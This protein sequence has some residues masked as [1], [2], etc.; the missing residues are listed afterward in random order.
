MSK[1]AGKDSYFNGSTSG[2]VIR[3]SRSQNKKG[4][5]NWID[6]KNRTT[7]Y[8]STFTCA[9]VPCIRSIF[10]SFL[11]VS[12]TFQLTFD[13]VRWWIIELQMILQHTWTVAGTP[14]V[15]WLPCVADLLMSILSPTLKFWP[16]G[17]LMEALVHRYSATQIFF[18]VSSATL[19]QMLFQ[20]NLCSG[21]RELYV[22]ELYTE[23]RRNDF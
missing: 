7:L 21:V 10:P 3:R 1:I 6:F 22:L 20:P 13:L 15:S 17:P 8:K 5:N 11:C 2:W 14:L 23:S 4:K 12:Y 9:A 16:P 19:Q 18:A